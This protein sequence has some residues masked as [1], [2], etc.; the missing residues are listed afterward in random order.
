VEKERMRIARDMHDDLGGS[1]TQI[2]ILSDMA[3]RDLASPEAAEHVRK[4]A[5]SARKTTQTLEEIV[6][7]VHPENDTLDHLANYL[8]QFAEEF[9]R[10]TGVRCRVDIPAMVPPHMLSAEA[11]HNLFLIVKESMNNALKYSG[12]SEI[13]LRLGVT[14]SSFSI[15]IEDNGRGFDVEK[16]ATSGNGMKNLKKRALDMGGR[17]NLTSKPGQGTRISVTVDLKGRQ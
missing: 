4:I 10:P 16:N 14:E 12:A 6:W 7:A 13:W 15:S 8:C 17:L 11:R 2:A 9:F 1:L 5:E 3:R